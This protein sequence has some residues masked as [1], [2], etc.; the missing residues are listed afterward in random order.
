[1]LQKKTLQKIYRNMNRKEIAEEMVAEALVFIET[2]GTVYAEIDVNTGE[3]NVKFRADFE[4]KPR[5][6]KNIWIS[7][8]TTHNMEEIPEDLPE[9]IK[10]AEDDVDLYYRTYAEDIIEF[11]DT[12]ELDKQINFFRKLDKLAKQGLMLSDE[13]L[14][15]L[16]E[17][18]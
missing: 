4:L 9:F 15:Q 18:K 14:K 13:S 1:M 7:E 2:D 5:Y 12:E 11:I 6:E 10:N 8:F 17:G 3:I 16:R